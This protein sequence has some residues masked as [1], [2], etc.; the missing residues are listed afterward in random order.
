MMFWSITCKFRD[1]CIFAMAKQL[2]HKEFHCTLIEISCAI[3]YFLKDLVLYKVGVVD[4]LHREEKNS[5][6]RNLHFYQTLHTPPL[7]VC[8]EMACRHTCAKTFHSCPVVQWKW[9]LLCG[10]QDYWC[11]N[12]TPEKKYITNELHVQRVWYAKNNIRLLLTYVVK[13]THY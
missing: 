4:E 7:L 9:T 1:K 6:W 13:P 11:W 12:S 2:L 5:D 3:P 10:S 8:L